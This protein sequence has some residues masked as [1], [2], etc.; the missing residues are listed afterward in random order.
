MK[1]IVFFTVRNGTRL[2]SYS[3]PSLVRIVDDFSAPWESLKTPPRKFLTDSRSQSLIN[4]I[5]PACLP[6]GRTE[7]LGNACFDAFP[8][9]GKKR[10]SALQ[11]LIYFMDYVYRSGA[12][13]ITPIEERML[14]LL[15]QR[16]YGNLELLIL[17]EVWRT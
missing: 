7:Q 16:K 11:S 14:K 17:S 6:R 4:A 1:G 13:D 12:R 2:D 15:S 9:K 10:C 3:E 8:L 5:F